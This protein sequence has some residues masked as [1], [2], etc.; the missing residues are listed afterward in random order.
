MLQTFIL[1]YWNY[2][3]SINSRDLCLMPWNISKTNR[4]VLRARA[5]HHP[6]L[7]ILFKFINTSGRCKITPL[8]HFLLKH[9]LISCFLHPLHHLF[10]SF[11]LGYAL[12]CAFTPVIIYIF[13]YFRLETVNLFFNVIIWSLCFK[14]S[15]KVLINI[16]FISGTFCSRNST[17]FSVDGVVNFW[18]ESIL[19]IFFVL[20][21]LFKL[22]FF[23]SF[24]FERLWVKKNINDV[25]LASISTSSILNHLGRCL[26]NLWGKSWI[27]S[28]LSV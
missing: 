8:S 6:F 5:C 3:A 19:S 24:W 14:L 9:L 21:T 4:K 17:Q 13:V 11:D 23:V 2:L 20:K 10:H 1:L 27:L 25:D 22:F 28:L 15:F 16:I 12:R 18:S 7:D 26:I